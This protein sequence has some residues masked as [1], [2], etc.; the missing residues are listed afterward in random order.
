MKRNYW[1]D[2]SETPQK[3][4]CYWCFFEKEDG[5]SKKNNF[6]GF[7]YFSNG[8]WRTNKGTKVVAWKNIP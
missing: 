7:G 8:E 6:Y 4:G 2:A 1:I 5:I 3:D